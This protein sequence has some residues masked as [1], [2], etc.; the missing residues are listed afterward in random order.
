MS[1]GDVVNMIWANEAGVSVYVYEGEHDRRVIQIRGVV[2]GQEVVLA[3]ATVEKHNRNRVAQ[4]F[5]FPSRLE[6]FRKRYDISDDDMKELRKAGPMV[7]SSTTQPR[8][9][10]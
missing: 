8:E 1:V 2:D 9:R 5:E 4:A 3:S 7:Q 6:Q 10:G